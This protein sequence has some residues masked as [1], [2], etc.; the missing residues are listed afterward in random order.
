MINNLNELKCEGGY[1]IVE[2]IQRLYDLRSGY[3]RINAALADI[4]DLPAGPCLAGGGQIQH[5]GYPYFSCLG[6][7]DQPVHPVAATQAAEWMALHAV[8][9]GNAAEG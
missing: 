5:V 4:V 6:D 2:P 3:D 9:P 7:F 1:P 8:D